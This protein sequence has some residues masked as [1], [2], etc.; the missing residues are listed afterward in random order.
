MKTLVLFLSLSV[1][2]SFQ[3][4]GQKPLES[5][6]LLFTQKQYEWALDRF[7]E[8][9]KADS[10]NVS[11]LV[12]AA[13]CHHHLLEDEKAEK[14]ITKAL[15]L[16]EHGELLHLAGLNALYQE[17]YSSAESHFANA[18]KLDQQKSIFFNA[19]SHFQLGNTL[20]SQNQYVEAIEAYN[21]SVRLEPEN[22]HYLFNR[23]LAN[24]FAGNAESGCIDW[25]LVQ[26]INDRIKDDFITS[27]CNGMDLELKYNESDIS[28][29]L[30]MGNTFLPFE[31]MQ[32]DNKVRDTL[33]YNSASQLTV[34]KSNSNDESFGAYRLTKIDT[35]EIKFSRDFQDYY[36]DGMLQCTGSYN[37][38]GL[39]H[40][41]FSFFYHSGNLLA[42]GSFRKG[43]M[44]DEWNF[45][46]EDNN[47]QH[48]V[49]IGLDEFDVL[50]SMIDGDPKIVEG[51]G[52]WKMNIKGHEVSGEYKAGKRHGEWV[53]KNINGDLLI[54]EIYSDGKLSNR[55]QHT[56][57]Q[58]GQIHKIGTDLFYPSS[59]D[60]MELILSRGLV[61]KRDY[62]YLENLPDATTL[63]RAQ[64]RELLYNHKLQFR[65]TYDLVD[66]QP[67]PEGG[68][69]E[70]YKYINQNLQ[71]PEDA[72]MARI[73]GKV[74]VMFMIDKTGAITNVRVVKGI[75]ESCDAEAARVIQN[76][77]KW[78]IPK[79]NGK[80]VK[81]RMIL[82]ITFKLPTLEGTT[83]KR[84]SF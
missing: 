84:K 12:G 62:P 33:F 51:N 13:M 61:T 3:A 43:K 11:A 14:L 6:W 50:Q 26:S 67:R 82:P 78:S 47:A 5:G 63:S 40:G 15:Q 45:F 10:S 7:E 49:L 54:T 18:I 9:L 71:Y 34:R 75:G 80:P 69:K 64:E 20:M 28:D 55:T 39:K 29:V 70:F 42:R 59:L 17:N 72:R 16:S 76:S 60:S 44:I 32:F 31:F 73:E 56:A 65:G 22:E 27:Y 36:L 35:D 77:S 52:K 23:S 1:V 48:S 68:M 24:L 19:D 58:S 38:D 21:E 81:V 30:I 41:R 83:M 74:F 37:Y 4:L 53:L 2:V 46:D 8:T 79:K 57:D 25:S 66:V